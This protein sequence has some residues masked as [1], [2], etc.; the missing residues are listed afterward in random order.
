MQVG[1]IKYNVYKHDMLLVRVHL[2]TKLLRLHVKEYHA[3]PI[4]R[5]AEGFSHFEAESL[6]EGKK[7]LGSAGLRPQAPRPGW[8]S[9]LI[10]E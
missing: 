9:S 6:D 1:L 8:N 3:H 4:D 10:E 5:R 7:R 2:H